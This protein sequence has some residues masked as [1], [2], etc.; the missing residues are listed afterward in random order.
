[1]DYFNTC[2]D[3]KNEI[4]MLFAVNPK[5]QW[6]GLNMGNGTVLAEDFYSPAM[7]CMIKQ[8]WDYNNPNE[9][10]KLVTWWENMDSFFSS[11]GSNAKR[12]LY[13]SENWANVNI[14]PYRPPS[15]NTAQCMDVINGLNNMGFWDDIQTQLDCKDVST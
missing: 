13:L 10:R 5:L 9:A 11:Y 3:Y 7:H 15:L 8:F 14:G 12:C 6:F 2:R 1:M 4:A